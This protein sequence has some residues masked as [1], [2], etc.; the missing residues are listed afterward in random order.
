M[1]LRITEHEP[2][3]NKVNLRI[4]IIS[5][6][7]FV[8]PFIAPFFMVLPEWYS[9]VLAVFGWIMIGFC[10]IGVA[11]LGYMLANNKCAT[12]EQKYFS[13]KRYFAWGFAALILTSMFMQGMTNLFSIYLI[14]VLAFNVE[15]Y[16][17]MKKPVDTETDS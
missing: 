17:W 5:A 7:V 12:I 16:M 14:L 13:P 10:V 1:T 15:S 3:S 9:T 4:D 11:F 8:V 2:T 6:I